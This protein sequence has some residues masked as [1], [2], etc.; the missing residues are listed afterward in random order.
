MLRVENWLKRVNYQVDEAKRIDA[1]VQPMDSA[2]MVSSNYGKECL[3]SRPVSVVSSTTSS[4]R[5]KVE[6]ERA[7]LVTRVEALKQRHE[8]EREEALLKAR[9]EESELQTAIAAANAKIEVLTVN[10]PA[11]NTPAEPSD[12]MAAYLC[13]A[14]SCSDGSF[15]AVQSD[16]GD[17]CQ[18]S[19]QDV[20][21]RTRFQNSS[22][23]GSRPHLL[24]AMVSKQP[25]TG[26]NRAVSNQPSAGQNRVVDIGDLLGVMQHLNE[27]TELLVRQQ[28]VST[29]P[30]LDIPVINGDPLEFGFF[31]KAFQHGI[32]DRTESNRDRLHFLEQ[33]THGRPKVLVRSCQ[34]MHP[35]IGYVEAKKLLNKHFGNEYT[36]AFA[37][38]ERVLKWPLIRSEDGEALT[39]FAVFLTGSCNTVD[40]MEYIEEMDS[41]TNMRAVIS[42]LP[43][44]LREKWR[45][46]ACDIQERKGMRARFTDLVSF[47]DKQA[48]IASH[49]L[50]GNIQEPTSSRDGSKLRASK[51]SAP[52]VKEKKN[53]FAT[54][55]TPVS[56]HT[57]QVKK[58]RENTGYTSGKQCIFCHKGHS[59]D[60]CKLIKQ[61]SHREKLDFPKSKGL[62]FGCLSQGHLSKGC[63][64]RHICQ[65][66]SLKHP[67]ILHLNREDL[68]S[69]TGESGNAKQ[70][71]SNSSPT[72]DNE[73]FVVLGLGKQPVHF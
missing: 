64:Q 1:E 55:V 71:V 26:Q 58:D 46:V 65:T 49:P 48:K 60:F 10:E 42:K 72:T 30:P 70:P 24:N 52:R 53:I 40:S 57:K 22:E 34:H 63:Q 6:A 15:R 45:G 4:A 31:M 19:K 62:C 43:F 69:S 12:G 36:I 11:Q 35:V 27:I 20:K 50:F 39:E 61:K 33:F 21:Q 66:C 41:P 18:R 5:L 25:S 73:T 44:K 16:G 38:I 14:H 28:K 17:L 7:A 68:A 56:S 47:V 3:G 37:Y 9:K 32:E 13:A 23:R 51:E 54:A 67:T 8:I 29:L 2:S 59:L